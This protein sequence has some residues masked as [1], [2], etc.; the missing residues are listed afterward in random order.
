MGSLGAVACF[1]NAFFAWFKHALFPLFGMQRSWRPVCAALRGVLKHCWREAAS[2]AG[3]GGA[4]CKKV[5]PRYALFLVIFCF[6]LINIKYSNYAEKVQQ[7]CKNGNLPKST[8]AK[9]VR[10]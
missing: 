5:N 4:S 7:L 1:F 6:A 8:A 9:L 2:C 3:R 10:D